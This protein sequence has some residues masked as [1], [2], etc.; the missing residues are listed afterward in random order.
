[1]ACARDKGLESIAFSL[2]SDGVFRGNRT[3]HK[4]L[5]IGIQTII[6]YRYEGLREVHLCG[7]N[8]DEY[9]ALIEVARDLGLT[10]EVG[11]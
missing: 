3:I 10:R 8:Q 4:V 7:Y 6:A 2:L 9:L 1:M 5:N 11:T